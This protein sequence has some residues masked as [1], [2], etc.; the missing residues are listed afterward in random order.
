[1]PYFIKKAEGSNGQNSYF[2]VLS[3]SFLLSAKNPA[4]PHCV[5][6][7]MMHK[8][9]IVGNTVSFYIASCICVLYL[10]SLLNISLTVKI[11]NRNSAFTDLKSCLILNE[12]I[13]Q[14]ISIVSILLEWHFI[15][16]TILIW[17]FFF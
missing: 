15:F 16:G 4:L 17:C 10:T 11:D 3:L 6:A 7:W 12:L 1:M 8:V 5:A 9:Y 13:S 2:D 14:C